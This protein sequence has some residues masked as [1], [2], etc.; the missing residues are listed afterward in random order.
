MIKVEAQM[1]SH[2]KYWVDY[3]KTT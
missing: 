1:S 3:E 2:L